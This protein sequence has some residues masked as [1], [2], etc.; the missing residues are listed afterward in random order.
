MAAEQGF[1]PIVDVGD[2]G[3]D[4]KHDWDAAEEEYTKEQYDKA[5]G[6]NAE[7]RL[8]PRGERQPCA[9]VDEAGDVQEL[10]ETELA[11]TKEAVV[12]R[13]TMSMTELKTVSSV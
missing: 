1:T 10:D 6:D 8:L 5:P 12:S 3:K 4:G 11:L 2:E 7:L 9:D 13:L